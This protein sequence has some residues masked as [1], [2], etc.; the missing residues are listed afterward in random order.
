MFSN[1]FTILGFNE[2]EEKVYLE[3]LKF[4]KI[5][6]AKVA[7]LTKVNRTTVYSIADKLEK[8]GL[9]DQDLGGK[10]SYLVATSPCALTNL[11]E[12]EERKL[13]EKKEEVKQLIERLQSFVPHVE[14]SVPKIKVVEEADLSHY[15]TKIYPEWEKSCAAVDHTWWGFH[16]SSFTAHYEA[17]IDG[18]WEQSSSDLQVKFFTEKTCIEEKM[19]E[20]HPN[21]QVKQIPKM[22]FDCSLWVVG[23]YIMLVKTREHPHYMI[24]IL[25]AVL[26]R[27]LR[28]LF[29]AFWEMAG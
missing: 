17:V 28:N 29:R 22:G 15:L 21:R 23:S 27:N 20:K 16:D 10:R 1:A 8:L 14:Y 3:V 18:H 12:A 2:N 7:K 24:E 6:P 13:A 25:D 26:A 11:I 9:I 19:H 4:G 5:S